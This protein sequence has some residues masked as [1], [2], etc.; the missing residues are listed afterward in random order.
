M[1]MLR[2]EHIEQMVARGWHPERDADADAVQRP[3]FTSVAWTSD[4]ETAVGLN[5]RAV[6]RT[7]EEHHPE[8]ANT[9]EQRPVPTML[10]NEEARTIRETLPPLNSEDLRNYLLEL[11]LIPSSQLFREPISSLSDQSGMRVCSTEAK[12]GRPS[13]QPPML[14]ARNSESTE[15]S[16]SSPRT[17]HIGPAVTISPLPD[18]EQHDWDSINESQSWIER[19]E[20]TIPRRNCRS[21][22]LW[23]PE[24]RNKNSLEGQIPREPISRHLWRL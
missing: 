3:R 5:D 11:F 1:T 21:A 12:E 22:E 9:G 13:H 23:C 15:I 7:V 14:E 6:D 20:W 2:I 18:V 4:G 16:A 10:V 19:R 8:V 24:A 17:T